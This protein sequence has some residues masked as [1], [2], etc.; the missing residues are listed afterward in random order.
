MWTRDCRTCNIEQDARIQCPSGW[1]CSLAHGQGDQ[2]SRHPPG[3]AIGGQP[4]SALTTANLLKLI[5]DKGRLWFQPHSHWV[6]SIHA[7]HPSSSRCTPRT[8]MPFARNHTKSS[9][10]ASLR[11]YSCNAGAS[12]YRHERAHWPGMISKSALNTENITLKQSEEDLQDDTVLIGKTL[13]HLMRFNRSQAHPGLKNQSFRGFELVWQLCPRACH[14]G[15]LGKAIQTAI[16]L[17]N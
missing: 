9:A 16:D 2:L 1:K 8:S 12:S 13:Y 3:G 10:A 7:W 4:T 6:P 11:F 17:I 5:N 14:Y 15:F